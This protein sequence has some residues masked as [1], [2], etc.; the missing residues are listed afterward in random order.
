MGT[1][2]S[3]PVPA[4]GAVSTDCLL[5]GWPG[6]QMGEQVPGAQVYNLGCVLLLSGEMRSMHEGALARARRAGD[7]FL[8]VV[9]PV[10]C[11]FQCFFAHLLCW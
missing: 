9:L 8:T 3:P 2:S 4:G 7:D 10:L 1:H 11:R 5:P 6:G